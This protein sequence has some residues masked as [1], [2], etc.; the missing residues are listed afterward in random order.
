L[1]DSAIVAHKNSTTAELATIYDTNGKKSEIARQQA[2]M[3]RQRLIAGA[4]AMVLILTFFVIYTLHKR[5]STHK[6]AA[7]HQKLQEAY[8]KLEETTAAKERIESELRI[9]RDI[10]QSMVPSVFP[11][12]EGLDLLVP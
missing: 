5:K 4:V 6:L 3:A 10:Q 9:A 12:R 2:D 7:A 1:L 8:D 11:N